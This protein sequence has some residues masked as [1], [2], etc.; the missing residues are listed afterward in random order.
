MG[1][2]ISS[3]FLAVLL[4]AAACPA[5]VLAE[6]GT[7]AG[8]QEIRET[9]EIRVT[10]TQENAGGTG[11]PEGTDKQESAVVS[12]ESVPGAASEEPAPGT[13]LEE[14]A[15][16][17]KSVSGNGAETGGSPDNGGNEE[18]GIPGLLDSLPVWDES[19]ELMLYGLADAAA[20]GSRAAGSYDRAYWDSVITRTVNWMRNGKGIV[21]DDTFLNGVSSTATDWYA[22]G[23]ARLGVEGE[24]YEKFVDKARAY[25]TDRYGD[26]EKY[27]FK[28]SNDRYTATEWHRLTVALQA[29]SLWVDGVDVTGIGGH[30]L[31]K[32]GTYNC[33]LGS[34][35]QQGPNGTAWALIAMDTKGYEAPENAPYG[36]EVLI[37]DLLKAQQSD[38]GWGLSGEGSGVDITGMVLQ[39]LAP[40]RAGDE[41]VKR[42]AEKG[43]Q[44]LRSA[45]VLSQDGSMGTCEGTVQAIVA[46][47]ALGMDPAEEES[48][49]GDSLLD[50]LMAYFNEQGGFCH[51]IG[52]DGGK[53]QDRMATEQALYAIAAYT[54]FL[55]GDTSLYD[56]R[57]HSDTAEYKAVDTLGRTFSAD[58]GAEAFLTLAPDVEAIVLTHLPL[59]D[60]DAAVVTDADGK[61]Y[62]TSFRRADG[63]IP[64]EGEIPVKD[65]DVLKIAVT[66]QDG[67]TENWTLTVETSADAAVNAVKRQINKLPGKET[68]TL[69][70]K[71]AVEAARK[72]Y[73]GL[74]PEQRETIDKTLAEKLD[75]LE[76]KLKQLEDDAGAQLTKK[77]EELERKVNAIPDVVGI[78]D[79]DTINGYCAQLD[80]MGDWEGK[81]ALKAKL[82]G[83][84]KAIDE[85]QALVEQVDDAIWNGIDPL[86]ISQDDTETV[87]KLMASYGALRR[88]E[89]AAL[90]N[91][92]DLLDAAEV[93]QSLEEGVVPSRVFQNLRAAGSRR[94]S[95]DGQS[96]TYYG[97][98]DNGSPY[99]LSWNAGD[100]T[101]TG[102]IDAGVA[103]LEGKDTLKGTEAQVE[104]AQQGGMNGK[105]RL[106][107]ES[108]VASGTYDLYWY[109]PDKLSVQSAKTAKVSSGAVEMDVT[110]GGRYWLSD[111][112]VRLDGN[113]ADGSVA[114]A[115]SSTTLRQAQGGSLT[116][117]TS[118]TART[119]ARAAVKSTTENAAA[120]SSSASGSIKSKSSTARTAVR[121]G[122]DSDTEGVMEAE[123]SGLLSEKELKEIKGKD[124][125]LRGRGKLP[126]GTEYTVTING[127]DV[128]RT[129]DFRFDVTDDYGKAIRSL[130][131]E[132]LILCLEKAG[133][134]PGKMLFSIK[135]DADGGA[136]LLFRYD[137]EK[138][139]AEYVK[140]VAAEDGMME[141]ILSEGGVYF[142]A[143]RAIAA[144]G[145]TDE[146]GKA[147][148]LAAGLGMNAD[149]GAEEDVWD[150][151]A[152]LMV[153]GT[154]EKA[155]AGSNTL[156]AVIAVAS[157]VIAV[158]AL[159]GSAFMFVKLGG[160]ER[161]FKKEDG[162]L[163]E[164]G[165][166]DD[167]E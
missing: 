104:L 127:K 43:V 67:T 109:N 107:V 76:A 4:F 162:L 74:T 105:A 31:I 85:R 51:E 133:E 55:N 79:R 106:S 135:K 46:F 82:D 32:D 156:L 155:G 16:F 143:E 3:L 11:I 157:C 63:S 7:P 52:A 125:N 119:T 19:Q 136:P 160:P 15:V 41:Q 24:P 2:R 118:S 100:V 9:S 33:V 58:A 90:K 132:P 124:Q 159:G 70:D 53:Q 111:S 78:S 92:A 116:S 142:I 49:S 88:E 167:R 26:P 65:G 50:G 81:A 163:L 27:P 102:D 117:K 14:P 130:A 86:N 68:I 80:S 42:A 149:S 147:T 122:G 83:C 56:F 94:S 146:A 126:D 35:S 98:L 36:R 12:E 28:M 131:E 89:K 103:L 108:N 96:F 151:S 140:K 77:R 95:S 93:I 47:T 38:G 66:R 64:V 18:Q 45:Q 25:V 141:F 75:A 84:L 29:A 113:N 37:G 153:T 152:E 44:Y 120:S 166:M 39:A 121:T 110:M 22:F 112:V 165:T 114:G 134:F 154:G 71:A 161:F 59:G 17:G 138:G 54:R 99:T 101:G 145:Q 144:A 48:F 20:Y 69:T 8:T 164:P 1:R 72:A 23:L 115:G 97:F 139:E 40:Y 30:D 91:A 158:A 21:L 62:K 87:K 137:P 128:V 123:E 57:D 73:D 13:V 34:P 5:S 60:Y 61:T 129:A 10:Q 148:V 6:N 150:E